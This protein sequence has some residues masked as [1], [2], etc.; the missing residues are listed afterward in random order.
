M[1]HHRSMQE[2][3][4]TVSGRSLIVPPGLSLKPTITAS[5]PVTLGDAT[6]RNEDEL[7]HAQFRLE[8]SEAQG[9]YEIASFGLDRRAAPIEIT[10]ALWRTVRVHSIIRDAIQ[11][12]LPLWTWPISELRHSRA[13]SAPVNAPQYDAGDEDGLLVAAISY[14]MAEVA[15]ENPALAVAETL[16][17][18]QRTA[19]NWIQRAKAA[20]YMSSVEHQ[21]DG[22]RIADEIRAMNAH[23]TA[24][25]DDLA[26]RL[27]WDGKTEE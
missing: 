10:G 3:L 4:V 17:L 5:I 1:W 6:A 18:K 9:R 7:P 8:Y 15:N 27:G 13:S 24:S 20:G 23:P 22:R 14:R 26:R 19:T 21:R 11:L 16:G 25:I 2:K 12:A